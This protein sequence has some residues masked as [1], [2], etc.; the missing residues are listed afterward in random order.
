MQQARKM[1]P[2]YPS[3]FGILG[4]SHV[5]DPPS[6]S[7]SFPLS[8]IL[9]PFF[10][11]DFLLGCL[12]LIDTSAWFIRLFNVVFLFPLLVTLFCALFRLLCS[13]TSGA[14]LSFFFSFF[15]FLSSKIFVSE[16]NVLL[17]AVICFEFVSPIDF[18]SF[19]I[20]QNYLLSYLR[21]RN[22]KIN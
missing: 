15:I 2:R 19:L 11:L 1:F 10:C 21:V 6:S 9:F 5:P 13:R 16:S 8:S 4:A 20:Y 12:I 14:K 17:F 18:T 22:I 7:S 3:E